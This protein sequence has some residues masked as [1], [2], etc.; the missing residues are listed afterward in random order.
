[1]CKSQRRR[2]RTAATGAIDKLQQILCIVLAPATRWAIDGQLLDFLGAPG[3]REFQDLQQ[4][5]QPVV[6]VGPYEHRS[7][8]VTW[9]QGV[10]TVVEIALAADGGVD[11]DHLETV[12]RAPEYQCRL[13]IGSCSAASNVTGR[14]SPAKAIARLLHAHDAC[15]C[16]DFAAGGPWRTE[17]L[18]PDNCTTPSHGVV[19]ADVRVPIPASARRRCY[20]RTLCGRSPPMN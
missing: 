1:M 16:F 13:R 11:P 12:L 15:A 4:Q 6:F 2:R 10:A 3:L 8:E 19:V 20:R 14:R 5:R 7:N 17:R 9:R 18:C